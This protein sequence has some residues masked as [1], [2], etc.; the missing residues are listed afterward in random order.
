MNKNTDNIKA[1]QFE[2]EIDKLWW[3]KNGDKEPINELL[4]MIDIPYDR[5][6]MMDL[7]YLLSEDCIDTFGLPKT[8]Q[9]MASF[10]PS[11]CQN[12][13]TDESEGQTCLNQ[14]C[15]F[16][17]NGKPNC[18]TIFSDCWADIHLYIYLAIAIGGK[19]ALKELKREWNDIDSFSDISFI[20]VEI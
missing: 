6:D 9:M 8:I 10:I 2:Y 16:Y 14:K 18:Y 3:G 7:G 17:N 15:S 1:L 4:K 12:I 13:H 20:I 19:S 11:N 5:E